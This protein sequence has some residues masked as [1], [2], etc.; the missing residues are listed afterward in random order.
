[1][2]LEIGVPEI[3][4]S[5]RAKL[6]TLGE[7]INYHQFLIPTS[8]IQQWYKRC[9]I[10]G[11]FRYRAL[12]PYSKLDLCYQDPARESQFNF[13]ERQMFVR[14]SYQHALIN[15][16]LQGENQG[17][18][19]HLLVFK[20]GKEPS[21]TNVVSTGLLY[22]RINKRTPSS[23]DL[24]YWKLFINGVFDYNLDPYQG[25]KLPITTS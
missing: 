13:W 6:D 23:Q 15:I 4:H 24:E 14:K 10:R 3:K 20:E 19:A 8:L 18:T 16:E 25:F 1:M 7:H 21:L 12:K 22:D 2:A 17:K 9:D 5:I 11:A